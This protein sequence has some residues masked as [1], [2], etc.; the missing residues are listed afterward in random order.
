MQAFLEVLD[1]KRFA[2]MVEAGAGTVSD[3]VWRHWRYFRPK[4]LELPP[5]LDAKNQAGRASSSWNIALEAGLDSPSWGLKIGTSHTWKMS[6][7]NYGKLM[8]F[9]KLELV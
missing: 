7:K 2:L 3:I 8:E 9:A 5:R 6:G 4:N 1:Y